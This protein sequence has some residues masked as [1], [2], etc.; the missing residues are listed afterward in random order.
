M[1]EHFKKTLWLSD[2]ES[3]GFGDI[4]VIDTS[5]WSEEDYEHFGNADDSE[6]WDVAMLIASKHEGK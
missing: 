6:K 1:I 5:S 2:D 4:L 3:Y